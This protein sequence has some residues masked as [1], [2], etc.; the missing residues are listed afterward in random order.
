MNQERIG[1][2][3]K[4]LRQEKQLTQKELAHKLGVTYQAVSKWENG[5]NIPDL[6][7]LKKIGEEFDCN[8][9]EL[10]NGEKEKKKTVSKKRMFLVSVF[11]LVL[12]LFLVVLCIYLC[13]SSPSK[14]FEFKTLSSTCDTFRISGS[15]AYNKEQSSIYIS[16]VEYCGEKE[17]EIYTTFTCTL[18]EKS[19][20]ILN[21]ISET[22]Y[23]GESTLDAYLKHVS[24]YVEDVKKVCKKYE[25]GSLYIEI[26]AKNENEKLTTYKIPLLLKNNY[27]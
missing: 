12:L 15:I 10:L 22:S 18:Y 11:F 2:F 16:H 27:K 3:I 21:K 24:F 13:T 9:N 8:L 6:F 4:H 14:N 5:K 25:E 19:G 1:K 17:E 20:N 7:I 26:E 23:E